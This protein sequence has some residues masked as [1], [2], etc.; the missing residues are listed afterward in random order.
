MH[1]EPTNSDTESHTHKCQNINGVH[2]LLML[3]L[4]HV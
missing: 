1:E 2:H 3:N 4:L